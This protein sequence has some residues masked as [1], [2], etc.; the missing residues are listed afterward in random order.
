M[1]LIYLSA[2]IHITISNLNTMQVAGYVGVMNIVLLA[3]FIYA[4]APASGGH[5]NP[6]IT[7][8]TMITGLTGF[9]R[10][11]LY[12]VAQTIGGALAGGL[13]RGSFGNTLTQQ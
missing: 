8:A 10:G 9:S 4:L 2:L 12:L 13:V 11:I 7:F 1:S 6:L 5:I 3:L